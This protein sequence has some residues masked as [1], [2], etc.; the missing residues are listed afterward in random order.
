MYN[1]QL[2][3]FIK[4]AELGSFGK[5][6]EALYISVPA[7][8]QQVNLLEERFGLKVFSRS[9]HGVRLTPAGRSLLEDAKTIIRLSNEALSKARQLAESAEATVR[10]ATAL[11][12]KCRLLPTIWTEISGQFPELKIE[13]LP[14]GDHQQQEDSF[15]ALGQQ[16]DLWEGIYA[17]KAWEGHCR[18]LELA[19]TPFCC[20]VSKNHRL[21]GEK[22][23]F[24]QDL[25]GEY[26]VMPIEGLSREMDTLR[27]EIQQNHPA[28]HIID[29]T[30]YGVDTF[31][32]CEVNPYVLITQA[33]Y[34]DI[35]TNLVTIPLD[36][37][38]TMPYR[39]IYANEPTT[40]TE[41]FIQA[42]E[43]IVEKGT[44]RL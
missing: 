34:A 32:L 1:H 27:A 21:A 25:N 43:R 23:L 44:L 35:H 42:A 26:L 19:R 37:S 8:I 31:T 17:D 36:V 24:L 13:I 11:L 12:F 10:I 16:Y 39:L 9:N 41:K 4:V 20:A 18:F 33:V 28:V 30:Y 38:Y 14:M 3:T 15:S 5:A 2:D 29:S 6:A 22:K 7:A 40:A